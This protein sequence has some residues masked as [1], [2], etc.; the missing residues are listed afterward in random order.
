MYLLAIHR[1]RRDDSMPT[2]WP[3][4]GWVIVVGLGMRALMMPSTPM[5]ETDFYRYL[6]DGAVLALCNRVD[7]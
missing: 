3:T 4:F 5:L 7:R 6:W 2:R 1:G